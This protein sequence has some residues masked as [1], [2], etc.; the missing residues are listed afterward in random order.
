MADAPGTSL[1]QV[2]VRGDWL[3]PE[4]AAAPAAC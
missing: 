2:K 4:Q 1:I 3:D